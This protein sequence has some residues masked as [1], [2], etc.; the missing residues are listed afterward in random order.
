MNTR[1]FRTFPGTGH[2]LGG[3]GGLA[4]GALREWSSKHDEDV[5]E[6]NEV[7]RCASGQVQRAA[8]RVAS[9]IDG[10]GHPTGHLVIP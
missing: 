3:F 5:T 9:M 10:P 7:L 8:L 2:Y 6:M 4:G 1:C